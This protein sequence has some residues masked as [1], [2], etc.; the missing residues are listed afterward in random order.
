MILI[1]IAGR[2]KFAE[3]ADMSRL[4]GLSTFC[5]MN[6]LFLEQLDV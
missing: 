3:Q 1:F 5:P 4:A 6:N 2:E